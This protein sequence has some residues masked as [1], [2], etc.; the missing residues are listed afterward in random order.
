[1]T[2]LIPVLI[3]FI[4]AMFFLLIPK[5]NGNTGTKILGFY[6]LNWTLAIASFFLST[7]KL[8]GIPTGL[9]ELLMLFFFVFI[10]AVPPLLYLYILFL[11]KTTFNNGIKHFVLAILLLLINVFSFIYMN[12]K[13]NLFMKELAEDLLT[14]S[15][16][17]A[18]LFVFPLLNLYYIYRSYSV[19]RRY[20]EE[21]KLDTTYKI[22]PS[23]IQY[24]ILGYVLFFLLMVLTLLGL[25]PKFLKVSF[26]LYSSIYFIYVAY[27][28]RT[29]VQLKNKEQSFHNEIKDSTQ[30]DA[31]FNDLDQKLSSYIVDEKPYLNASLSLNE[32]AKKIGTNEKYLSIFINTRY[33]VNFAT[34]INS[35]RLEEAKKMLLSND[36]KQYTIESIANKSGFNSK[37]SFNSLFKKQVGMTPTDFKNTKGA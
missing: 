28:N 11:A 10:L 1:M 21:Y 22:Q 12:T 14:Y 16:Y 9:S 5:S 34:F 32:L 35:Y 19:Y 37:S 13:K 15:N 8:N 26:E 3:A 23:Q 29:Q 30:F 33:G 18:L 6:F 4:L 25:V 20:K 36:F 17:L 27:I 31:L 2:L 24:F 7:E